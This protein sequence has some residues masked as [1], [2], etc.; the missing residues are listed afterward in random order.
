MKADLN[1]GVAPPP[2]G[3]FPDAPENFKQY[4]KDHPELQATLKKSDTIHKIKCWNCEK[5]YPIRDVHCPFCGKFNS[6]RSPIR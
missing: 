1:K 6:K 5:E 4:M 2:D 3:D